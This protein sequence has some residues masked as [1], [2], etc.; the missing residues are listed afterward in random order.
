L[1]DGGFGSAILQHRRRAPGTGFLRFWFVWGICRNVV[2]AYFKFFYRLSWTGE[3]NIPRTG[4]L[5]YVCNHT[6]HF[7]PPMVGVVTTVRPTSFLAR[8]TLFR[9]R[10]WGAVLRFFN[11]IPI[12]RGGRGAEAFRAA[13]DEL[14]AGR[15]V[16]I[17][18]EGTRSKTG[19]MGRFKAGFHLLARRTGALVVPVGTLGGETIWPGSRKFPKLFGRIRCAVGEPIDVSDVEADDAIE[20]TSNAVSKLLD[21]LRSSVTIEPSGS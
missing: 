13:F 18:P 4:P 17:F 16:L 12:V 14:D 11:S 21:D 3:E 9:P 2:W 8:D 15:C 6:T 20:L 19:E 10:W 7:D 1:S 5:I